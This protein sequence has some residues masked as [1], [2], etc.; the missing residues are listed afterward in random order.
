MSGPGHLERRINL[1]AVVHDKGAPRREATTPIVRR[2]PAD[3]ADDLH[4]LEA[5]V[6]IRLRD[7]RQQAPSIRMPRSGEELL[8]RS[9]FDDPAEV[10]HA[11]PIADV[12]DD[13]QI[14][15]D[16]Q[17][18]QPQA[19]LEIEEQVQDLRLDRD[20]QR[21]RGLVQDEQLWLQREGARDPDPLALSAT[22]LV[23]KAIQMLVSQPHRCN[24]RSHPVVQLFA[25]SSTKN[26]ERLGHGR[27][28]GLTRI[29]RGVR[30]LENHLHAGPLELKLLAGELAQVFPFE[31]DLPGG[32]LDQPQNHLPERGFAWAGL[33]HQPIGSTSRDRE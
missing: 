13:R 33:A 14:V 12:T 20:V 16:E 29:E 22:E 18:G 11:H 2:Q 25:S 24:Q 31:Q 5:T 6:R 28:D 9:L 21:G 15:R 4:R 3:L 7:G 8:D 23:G 32:R 1:P 10:H 17:V 27:L 30:V 19:L 26:D